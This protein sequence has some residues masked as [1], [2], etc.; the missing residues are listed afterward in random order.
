MKGED[1]TVNEIIKLLDKEENKFGGATE[2]ER[3]LNLSVN[4]DFIGTIT[5]AKLDGWGDGLITDVTLEVE[6]S[7][8]EYHDDEIR[9]KAIDEFVER[10]KSDEF[11]KYNLDM[12]FETSRNLSYSECIDAFHEYIDEIAEQMKVGGKNERDFI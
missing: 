7:R 2:K 3:E 1:M 10:L 4:G 6:V 11:Q 8:I 9:A 12:V 5:N